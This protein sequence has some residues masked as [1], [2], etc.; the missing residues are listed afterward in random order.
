MKKWSVVLSV[1]ATMIVEVEANTE[2]EA[3]DKA[4][5]T[6]G[7]PWLCHQCSRDLNIGDVMDALE[8]VEL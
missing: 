7:T 6:A 4:I 1:D 5:E 8:V 2:E 3:K